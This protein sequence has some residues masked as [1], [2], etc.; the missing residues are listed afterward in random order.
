MYRRTRV[1]YSDLI[2]FKHYL[3][4]E[5]SFFFAHCF[6]YFYKKLHS[7]LL[8]Q[9]KDKRDKQ[10]DVKNELASKQPEKK[11]MEQPQQPKVVFTLSTKF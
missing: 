11:K 8:L 10:S 2:L 7:P 4:I 6:P 1:H 3:S 5:N 9:K